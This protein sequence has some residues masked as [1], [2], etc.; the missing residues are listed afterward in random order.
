MSPVI[1]EQR[2]A[3][4]V[5]AY[6][7]QIHIPLVFVGGELLNR[8]GKD[9]EFLMGIR[10]WSLCGG[11]EF[12]WRMTPSEMKKAMGGLMAYSD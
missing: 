2:H 6:C 1:M 11:F 10:K 5:P 9:N 8:I 7:A 12:P 3:Q 4:Y